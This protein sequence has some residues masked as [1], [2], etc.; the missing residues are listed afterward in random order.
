MTFVILFL[1]LF[2]S[3][4]NLKRVIVSSAHWLVL[5]DKQTYNHDPSNPFLQMVSVHTAY[6]HA[7]ITP[8]FGN[9]HITFLL[10]LYYRM[11]FS[12]PK[13]P[14]LAKLFLKL[15][16]NQGNGK[17][18]INNLLN[19]IKKQNNVFVVLYSRLMLSF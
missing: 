6:S 4:L 13:M 8:K 10:V 18:T 15:V 9:L 2:H 3:I 16:I 12:H 5:K 11:T 19:S 1:R 14:C 17:K 7:G